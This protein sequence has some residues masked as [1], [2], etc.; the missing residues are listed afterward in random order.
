MQAL[1]VVLDAAVMNCLSQKSAGIVPFLKN[2][3]EI[4]SLLCRLC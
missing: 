3:D 4:H 2:I 1:D